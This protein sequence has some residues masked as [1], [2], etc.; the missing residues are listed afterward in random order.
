MKLFNFQGGQTMKRLIVMI[1]AA[2]TQ[3]MSFSTTILIGLLLHA[4]LQSQTQLYSE[5]PIIFEN[6]VRKSTQLTVHFKY[7]VLDLPRGTRHA[8]ITDIASQFPQL[9]AY[10]SAL[11]NR[12]G[13]IT[14]IKQI[15]DALWGD[16]WRAN[17]NTGQLVRIHD[18]SQLFKM[19]FTHF[20]PIDSII[21]EL[22]KMDEVQYA[23]QPIQT[24]S[25]ITPNDPSYGNQWNLSKINASK[26]WDVTIGSGTIK[27]G[28][29]GQSG[30][31]RDHPDLS[32]KFTSEGDLDYDPY[33]NHETLV[34]GVAG[35]ATNNSLGIASLG[36]QPKLVAYRY[37]PGTD[38]GTLPDKILEAVDDTCRVINCS[39]STA[40]TI[41]NPECQINPN[42]KCYIVTPQNY[43][44]VDLAIQ[45][46]IAQGVVVVASAG[47]ESLNAGN[48]E[49]QFCDS[50]CDQ[51]PY[52]AYP[53]AYPSVIGVSATD[54]YDVFA[55][56]LNW[57]YGSFIDVAA[58]GIYILTTD[59]NN[60]YSTV[61]GTSFS[62]PLVAA[63]AGLIKSLSVQLS[64]G[65][66]ENIVRNTAVDL[67]TSG[68][69]NYYGYG[70]I[71]TYQTLLL[72][73]AYSNKSVSSTATAGNNGRRLVKDSSGKYHLV[74][75]SGITSGGNV[76]SEIFYRNSTDGVTWSTPVRLSAGNEQ[77]R[78]VRNKKIL[79]SHVFSN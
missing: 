61:S 69:D 2:M 33:D 57:N 66:V 56:G 12:Y 15:P 10:F 3:W 27:I 30:V 32:S 72:T 7:P 68:Q 16:V 79:D 44:S 17:F 37:T 43:P 22:Q 73:H 60:G 1:S 21:A 59:I 11:R 48:P 70:R 62:S 26:A 49:F 63:L 9:I 28:L 45:A 18:M 51:F 31:K 34:A 77:N 53:A 52:T 47:N 20:V 24:I 14:L 36:W 41:E 71:D 58:P 13:D 42:K 78:F 29:I 6:G 4:P 76:L 19:A 23:H 65:D 8:A 74:F 75:E 40:R 35:A 67:G 38:G 54:S 39:F 50:M 25:F 5:A 64:S 46:A 55:G